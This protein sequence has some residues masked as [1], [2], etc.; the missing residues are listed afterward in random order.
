MCSTA[1]G[2]SLQTAVG[3]R[4]IEF[5]SPSRY[6]PAKTMMT[7]ITVGLHRTVPGVHVNSTN[8]ER[9]QLCA[10]TDEHRQTL[11]NHDIS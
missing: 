11:R 5:S 7:T 6:L 3:V 2:K 10:I 9:K 4:G 1:A 8:T